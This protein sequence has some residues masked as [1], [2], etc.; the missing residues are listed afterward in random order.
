VQTAI[1]VR[2]NKVRQGSMGMMGGSYNTREYFHGRTA[3]FLKS[4]K[5]I[6]LVL[7]FPIPLLL[8]WIGLAQSNAGLL[9]LA[10]VVQYVGLLF[11]RWFFF[12]QANHPQ[13]LYYQ[14]ISL[15][16]AGMD[17]RGLTASLGEL[18]AAFRRR[19]GIELRF[20]SRVDDFDLTAEQQLQVFYIVQEA[21]ANIGH[22]SGARS[23]RLAVDRDGEALRVT[24]EDDG[25]GPNDDILDP[26]WAGRLAEAGHHGLQI[27]RE[28]AGRAGGRLHIGAAPEGGTRL[29]LII[30]RTSGGVH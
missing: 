16:R 22:H 11:E 18:A 25:R 6:F 27:M 24:V 7:V 30:D 13:N 29:S 5:W 10:F 20:D 3:A 8:L 21:L 14:V 15:Y 26:R 1:G 19:T 4:V 2:H 28:R 17:S 12:A 23:A 9:M